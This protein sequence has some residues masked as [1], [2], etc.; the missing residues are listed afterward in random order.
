VVGAHAVG[1]GLRGGA[2]ARAAEQ[3]GGVAGAHAADRS[4][5]AGNDIAMDGQEREGAADSV[6]SGGTGCGEHQGQ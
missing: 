6:R 5:A 1:Y 2:G 4:G 3:A